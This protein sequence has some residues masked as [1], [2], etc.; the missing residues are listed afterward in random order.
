MKRLSKQEVDLDKLSEQYAKRLQAME[1]A[2]AGKGRSKGKGKDA[3]DFGRASK[4][5]KQ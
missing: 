1:N 2:K 5:K 4:R 3:E